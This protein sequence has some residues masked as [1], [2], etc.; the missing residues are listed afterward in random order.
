[1]SQRMKKIVRT[2]ALLLFVLPYGLSRTVQ[3]EDDFVQIRAV[4]W[5]IEI[6]KKGG[7]PH[8]RIRCPEIARHLLK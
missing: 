2:C 5:E 8:L 4:L 3:G 7:L 1:M 6:G